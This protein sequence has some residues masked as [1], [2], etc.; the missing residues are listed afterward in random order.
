M[1]DATLLSWINAEVE[2]A[3]LM[4]RECI[5]RFS[6]APENQE[7]LRPCPE[8]LH[9]VSGALRMVG[10][11]GA[12]LV[13]E[14]IEGSFAG[15]ASARP[16]AATM[17]II[18]RAVLALKDFVGDLARGQ[19]DVPLR[20]FPVYRDLAQLKGAAGV[21]EKD[22][23]FPD[24]A[25]KAPP[26][27]RPK[28]LP[29]ETVPA[30][31]QKQR[32]LF[33]RGLL[34]WLR[35]P[36]SGLD[37]M[38]RAVNQLHKIAAQLPEPQS[39]WWVAHGF[40]D[41][42]EHTSDPEWLA[43]AKALGNR[44]EK[45][46]RG[47][48]ATVTEALL[49]E[50]LYAIGKAKPATQRLKDVRQL[51]QIDSLF[52]RQDAGPG[53][54]LDFDIERLEVA[55]YD[56]HS[57]LDAL[58][59][60]W[61]QYVSGE[62]K[63]AAP[64]R[65]RVTAFRAKA[66]DLGNQHLIKLLDAIGLV[67]SK[68]PDPY[69][70]QTQILV[71]EMA[72]AFLLVEHVLDNFTN[73][74]P[75]LEQQIAIMGGWLLDA[76]MGKSTGEPPPGVRPD[77]S[78]RI[79]ALHLR[80]QV[81]K[82]ILANLQHVEQVLDAFARDTSKRA[83]LPELQP[84]LRQ[85]HGALVVLGLNRAAEALAICEKLIAACAR[86]GHRTLVDD[87]DWI[88]E[89][90][91]SLGFFLE[92]CRHGREPAEEAIDLFFRRY[93][94]RDAPPSL[95]TT[96]RMKSPV[97][98]AAPE[99]VVELAPAPE[100][101]PKPEARAGVDADLL[102]IFLEE[103]GEVLETIDKT[104][105]ESR[106]R[107]EDREALT[108]I[109]RG[110]H[111]LKGSGRMVGLM[112]LGEAAWEV[113]RA[114]N[115]WLEA[116]KPATP[117][118]LELVASAS[119]SFAGWIGALREG[120]LNQE[121]N[122]QHLVHLAA[123][124]D[125][126]P[127]APAAPPQPEETTIGGVTLPRNFFDIYHKEAAEHVA[128]LEAQCREWRQMPGAE[129]SHEFMRAA[130]TLASSSRTA[131][132]G[133]LA[134]LAAALEHWT[135]FSARTTAPADGELIQA[136]I[137]KLRWMVDGLAKRQAP[138]PDEAGVRALRAL[139]ARIEAQPLPPVESKP[140][141]RPEEKK[142]A[143]EPKASVEPGG[144]EKRLMRDDID[145]QLLPIFLEE[146]QQ[147]V[148]Q[149]GADLRDWKANPADAKVSDSL[150]RVLHTFKGSAR[151][152]G[153]IR[154]GELCHIMETRVEEAIE[155]NAFPKALWDELEDKMD[156]LSLDVE[157]METGAPEEEERL[158]VAAA[159]AAPVPA[160]PVPA[161]QPVKAP[162]APRAEPQR[163]AAPLPSA[164]ATLRVNAET[165][166]HLIN[167]SGEVAIARSRVEAELRAVKQALSDLT[168]S[169]GRIRA[170]LRE[171]EVQADSQM[172]SRLSVMDEQKSE[173][174]PLEFDRYTRLQELT[175][176]MAE[177]LSDIAS[178]Q[179]GLL[180][181]VGDTDAALL[182][183]ARTSR[184]VQQNLMRIRAVPFSNLN[185]RLYR[186]VRQTARE[187][188]KKADLVI[189]GSE[190]ELDRSVLERIGAPLEHMLRNALAH[191]LESPGARVAAG[192]PETGR[193]GISLRQESNE[194][195]LVVSD[196]GAGLDLEKL[197]RK[198]QEMGLLPAE[199]EPTEAQL[200]QLIF[201]SGLSTADA[202]S[203]LAGR[204]VGMDVVKNEITVIGGRIE[205]ASER[206]KGT[207]FAVHLPLTLAVT[208]VVLVRSGG[209][210]LAIP[211]AMVEQVMRMKEEGLAELYSKQSVAFQDRVYPLHYIRTLLGSQGATETPAYHSVLLLRSGI[212]RIALHVDELIGN[213]EIVVKSIGPHLARLPGVAGATVLA[214]GAIVLIVNPVQLAAR[215]RAAAA[216]TVVPAEPAQAAPQVVSPAI[217][218]VD[219]SLTVRKIT[220]RLLERE[221]YRVLTAK[222]GVDALE[223][224]KDTLPGVLLVDIEMPRMDGFDLTRAVR[225]DPRLQGIPIIIISSRT[226]EKHRARAA[227]L[228][229][230]AFLGKP[231]QESELLQ[232]IAQ[233]LR[234]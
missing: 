216:A 123:H 120:R 189:E 114:M 173:F 10:L 12:T 134:D 182:Q 181:N 59:R 163:P 132:F 101:A 1:A 5:A 72:S 3:L 86:E 34:A 29:P 79:G 108:T 209:T 124:L 20:L 7:A 84:Y 25:I 96:M 141:P 63:T 168:D 200:A 197:R 76:A 56:L 115:R 138:A 40:L 219:D 148:P 100:P 154:L 228:G 133:A 184:E 50:L 11:N 48:A 185:E 203:E 66:R 33:Q 202:V 159:P 128:N 180:K 60:A 215:A 136:T 167:E 70:R 143:A 222:D 119:K 14:S 193:I 41:A 177:G 150:R 95:D 145:P 191:G 223:Q 38:R 23:F 192:K 201:V 137:A 221:G 155:N 61:V 186:I 52:P 107:P 89:G 77:L 199:G 147:L 32:A 90:L 111:T 87:M 102:A 204:G 220:T 214:D 93:E 227:E 165:L 161:A 190:V 233:H 75:D 104:A 164:A 39:I 99:L 217:M 130:H 68:L 146:A 26:H 230:N 88:A 36:P 162:A 13:C 174:D 64:F 144:R 83:T 116:K 22:L 153:A 183:Q 8:H 91:S 19:A 54:H 92:P 210:V 234:A 157:R 94:K 45:Q 207:T 208:Q 106:A 82:E 57:R 140:K 105:A 21:S 6:A 9:Q 42:V 205:I 117:A 198:G 160:A 156:R 69:P 18:D 65:E 121:V 31:V 206:G 28:T 47:D 97:A 51:Y 142:P 171:V 74:A 35:N 229:V 212:Q 81:A 4:V 27:R 122:A 175:R 149:L 44:I 37:D 126:A 125:D 85:M 170:Q 135:G 152:A 67:A 55:L 226:A 211:A 110:F 179:Q 78:E 43:A 30:F 196:D 16:T 2:R 169:I 176:M 129:T 224:M 213:E 62:H 139:V 178:L 98:P 231:Y 71:I 15:F 151:M 194:I 218:V 103:A 46:M 112:D 195:A 118:L 232:H 17:G 131:G 58:K 113:E 80:S 225:G 73:P 158:P 49:R 109:R 166:D 53:V 188:D 172:Q 127:A 24:V 187:L